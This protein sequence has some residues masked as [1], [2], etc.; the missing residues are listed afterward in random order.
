MKVSNLDIFP[1]SIKVV[2]DFLTFDQCEDVKNFFWQTKLKPHG[3]LEKGGVS[4]YDLDYDFLGDVSNAVA[5]CSDLKNKIDSLL[6]EY[7]FKTGITHK[8]IDRSWA[9]FQPKESRL[10][11]HTHPGSS[12]TGALYISVKMATPLIL[13]NPNPYVKFT[14]KDH[15]TKYTNEEF[16]IQPKQGMVILFPSWILHSTDTSYSEER[17]VV[18]FNGGLR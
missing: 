12:I 2:E 8:V 18:S 5:S 15:I 9:N 1:V 7:S 10:I 17:I 13:H 6:C 3:L 14:A 11:P 4:N 16:T